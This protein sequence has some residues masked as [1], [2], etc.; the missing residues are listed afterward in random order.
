[1]NEKRRKEQLRKQKQ[2]DKDQRKARRLAEKKSNPEASSLDAG[3][4]GIVHGPQPGQIIDFD[5]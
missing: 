5:E 1:M 4:E 3:L 2:Q